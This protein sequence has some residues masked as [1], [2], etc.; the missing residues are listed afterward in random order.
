MIEIFQLK[1]LETHRKDNYEIRKWKS[2]KSSTVILKWSYCLLKLKKKSFLWNL[3][4]HALVNY[5][6]M[7]HFE[8]KWKIYS[9]GV[10]YHVA[11]SNF[12]SAC[13]IQSYW[14]PRVQI[15]IRR[16]VQHYVIKFVNDL[17]QVSG[18]LWVLR[19]PPPIKLTAMIYMKYCWI[20]R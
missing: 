4:F 11:A 18:F 17:R 6:K 16:G 9:G 19:F 20:S 10:F 12:N 13:S 1:N 2:L 8:C 14:I 15:S 7:H 3:L 5:L